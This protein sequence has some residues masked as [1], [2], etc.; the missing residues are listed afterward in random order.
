MSNLSDADRIK[1]QKQ[2]QMAS[3]QLAKTAELIAGISEI[4][5]KPIA[6]LSIAAEPK[7]KPDTQVNHRNSVLIGE[8]VPVLTKELWRQ[9]TGMPSY[10][11]TGISRASITNLDSVPYIQIKHPAKKEAGFV[12]GSVLK[13]KAKE[14]E[15][16]FTHRFRKGFDFGNS[17]RKTKPN[18][19]IEWN[20]GKYGVGVGGGKGTKY[21][22]S[23]YG[24]VVPSGGDVGLYGHSM[25]LIWRKDITGRLIPRLYCYYN[26]RWW[27]TQRSDKENRSPGDELPPKMPQ[28]PRVSNNVPIIV[29]QDHR[30][31]L[32]QKMNTVSPD[33]TGNK[34]G[35][36]FLSIDGVTVV[37]QGGLEWMLGNPLIEFLL[38]AGHHGGSGGKY[39]PSVDSFQLIKDIQYNKLA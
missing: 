28:F 14:L 7:D 22:H 37:D 30:Y 25:R 13:E 38:L 3:N 31:V 21:S 27:R 17:M 23:R 8:P 24:F 5:A 9:M 34:D 36:A 2:L 10:L 11:S 18:E 16:S 20:H 33:G 6:N 12:I 32:R 15:V 39:Q 4:I 1:A 26:N 19:V 29:G 35:S